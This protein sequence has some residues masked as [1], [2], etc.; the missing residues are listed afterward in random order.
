MRARPKSRYIFGNCN[1]GAQAL[2]SASDHRRVFRRS[3]AMPLK[4]LLHAGVHLHAVAALLEVGE[5]S[6]DSF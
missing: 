4:H 6:G 3:K 1:G 5:R 2:P